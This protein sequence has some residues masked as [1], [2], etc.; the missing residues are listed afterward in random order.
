MKKKIPL[1]ILMLVMCTACGNKYDVVTQKEVDYTEKNF[2]ACKYITSINGV[3]IDEYSKSLGEINQDDIHVSCP[4]QAITE[5]GDRTVTV[6]I[7]SVDVDLDFK[8]VDKQ[9][10]VIKVW[11]R[12]N[13]SPE[14]CKFF[15]LKKE[16]TATDNYDKNVKVGFS[17]SYDINTPGD[18]EII[19]TAQDDS[20]NIT[21]KVVRVNVS[22]LKVI[23]VFDVKKKQEVVAKGNSQES[24]QEPDVEKAPI[25]KPVSPLETK[26]WF[27]KDGLDYETGF[28]KCVEYR[29]NNAGACKP[30]I[31]RMGYYYGYKYIPK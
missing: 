7:N 20:K 23:D 16:V 4:S 17:G 3:E 1:M 18:Y 8:L 10:P 30:M 9:A 26:E 22:D 14:N 19:A 13:L 28:K 24:N 5:L 6:S 12:Y 15:D 11:E 21:T 2:D 25:A 31:D 29:G 27:F